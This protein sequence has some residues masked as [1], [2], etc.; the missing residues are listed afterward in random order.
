MSSDN[1]INNIDACIELAKRF[2]KRAAAA[3]RVLGKRRKRLSITGSPDTAGMLR[4]S[5]DLTRGLADLRVDD[6]I[7][8]NERVSRKASRWL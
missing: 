3:R 8:N 2:I 4:S 5:L 7:V 6:H 1:T